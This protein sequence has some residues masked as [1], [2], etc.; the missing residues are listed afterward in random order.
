MHIVGGWREISFSVPLEPSLNTHTQ[1]LQSGWLWTVGL[2]EPRGRNEELW[3]EEG[4]GGDLQ[5]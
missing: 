4:E 3:W 5:D 1:E 2:G